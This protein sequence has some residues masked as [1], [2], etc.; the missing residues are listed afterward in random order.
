MFNAWYV[1]NENMLAKGTLDSARQSHFAKYRSLVP[2]LALIF[3][4][5]DGHT[6]PVCEDCLAR[7]L[8]FAKYLKSHANRIYASISGHDHAAVRLLAERLLDGQLPDGFTCRTLTLKGWSGLST[9]DQASGAIDALVE[10][11]WLI[12]EE[13]RSS[14]R[15]SVKYSLNP[16]ASAD[17]L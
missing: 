9:K 3:H 16:N 12:E 2:A 6:G 15:P 7:A 11:G 5:L 1:K 8:S 10:Y 13:I 4:L 17:L 14:G